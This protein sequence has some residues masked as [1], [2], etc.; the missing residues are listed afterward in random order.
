MLEFYSCG[1]CNGQLGAQELVVRKWLS[2]STSYHGTSDATAAGD[3]DMIQSVPTDLTINNRV[4][5]VDVDTLRIANADIGARVPWGGA[6][7]HNAP[8]SVAAI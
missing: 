1:L 4:I 3:Y 8:L 6:I 7:P 2:G 5:N